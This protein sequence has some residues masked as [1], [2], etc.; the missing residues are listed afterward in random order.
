M[1]VKYGNFKVKPLEQFSIVQTKRDKQLVKCHTDLNNGL[2]CAVCGK[3]AIN[4][5]V[6]IKTTATIEADGTVGELEDGNIMLIRP[7]KCPHCDSLNFIE[8]F[9]VNED[10]Y[11]QRIN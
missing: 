9:T 11:G 3:E 5:E 4:F 8:T 6:I 1:I 7:I 2:T 10:L